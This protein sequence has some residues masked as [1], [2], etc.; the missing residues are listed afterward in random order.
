[1]KFTNA[2]IISV[3]IAILTLGAVAAAEDNSTVG[4]APDDDVLSDGEVTIDVNDGDVYVIGTDDNVIDITYP[5]EWE[6]DDREVVGTLSV[7]LNSQLVELTYDDDEEEFHITNNPAKLPFNLTEELDIDDPEL[8]IDNLKPGTYEIEIEF[9]STSHNVEAYKKA[10]IFINTA[11]SLRIT[12]I[13]DPYIYGNP[14]NRV[15]ITAPAALFNTLDVKINGT[16]YKVVKNNANEGYVNISGLNE[17]T[18]RIIA[19]A[20]GQTVADTITVVSAIDAPETMHYSDSESIDLRLPRDA[21]GN[22]LITD[23]KNHVLFNQTLNEGVAS[24]PLSGFRVG[25]YIFHAEYTGT[26]YNIESKDINLKVLPLI[27]YPARMGV[28][29]NKFLTFDFGQGSN[30]VITI[31]ADY[32]RYASVNVVNGKASV[33]L[34]RLEDGNIDLDIEYWGD[35][36]FFFNVRCEIIVYGAIE[37]ISG[38]R[39]IKMTYGDNVAYRVVAYSS[40]GRFAEQGE[41]ADVKIGKNTYDT[42]VGPKGVITFNIPSS[43]A[44]GKYKIKVIYGRASVETNLVIKHILKLKKV[45]VKRSAKKLVLKATLK[46][47]MKGKKIIFKFNGKKFKAKTNKKGVAKVTI[48]KKFL[49]KLKVGKKVKIQA[50]YLKDTVKKSVK[51]KR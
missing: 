47:G 26:D 21:A 31:D 29:E 10:T 43:L 2:I 30:G 5:E 50:T 33:S 40:D 11:D 37:R 12:V 18:Y 36:G 39:D 4:M 38:A 41:D 45:K 35:D 32:E 42:V 24:Y 46:K 1:M 27:I 49:T 6:D 3:L 9:K 14:K 51:V 7:K 20:G 16:G 8:I 19:T 48:K 13:N 17:G 23:G 34:S 15:Y 28:G 25:D 44:P 22:L